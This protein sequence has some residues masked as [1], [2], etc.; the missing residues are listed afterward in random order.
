MAGIPA[1]EAAAI[2]WRNAA[3]L[4]RHPVPQSVQDDPNAF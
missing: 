1:D 2:C 3:D 4:Y